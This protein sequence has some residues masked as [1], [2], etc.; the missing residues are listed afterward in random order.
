MRRARL[1]SVLWQAPEKNAATHAGLLG[2]PMWRK[3]CTTLYAR[4]GAPGFAALVIFML[5]LGMGANLSTFS[6]ADAILLRMLQVKDPA[7]LYRTAH[8]TGNTYDSGN[9]TSYPLYREMQKRSSR[10]A[11][12]MAYQ[13]AEPA[14]GSI[15]RSEQERLM[16]QRVSGNYFH[17]CAGSSRTNDLARR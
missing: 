5:A 15:G 3:T 8:A 2:F 7:S 9:A 4:L 13:G 10:L 17:V 12:L 16:H 6:V 1:D 11:E 14:P